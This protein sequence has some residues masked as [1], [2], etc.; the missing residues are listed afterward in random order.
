MMSTLVGHFVVSQKKRENVQKNNQ[1]T[2]KG[3]AEE[4]EEKC[5]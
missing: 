1:M 3:G 5:E 4:T 2:G